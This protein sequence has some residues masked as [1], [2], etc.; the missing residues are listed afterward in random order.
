MIIASQMISRFQSTHPHGVRLPASTLTTS[1]GS[2]NPRTHTGCDSL[3]SPCYGWSIRRFNPR[4]HTGCDL[5]IPDGTSLA[6]MFQSTHP[7]GVR[8][9]GYLSISSEIL[10][11]QST[12]PHGVRR[13]RLQI[14]LT[15]SGFNPRT[16]T[17]CDLIKQR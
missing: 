7:H 6:T 16:H 11:F 1:S 15:S 3:E 5:L 10:S 12:H 4:T 8:L 9:F 14:T 17:G 13:T 2:F